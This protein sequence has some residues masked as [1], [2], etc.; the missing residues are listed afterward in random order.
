MKLFQTIVLALLL[1]LVTEPS[2]GS[3]AQAQT[4]K[5]AATAS[6]PSPSTKTAATTP[7]DVPPGKRVPGSRTKK[8]PAADWVPFAALGLMVF[9]FVALFG[10]KA[11]KSRD[12]KPSNESVDNPPSS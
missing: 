11:L 9:F 7:P 6:Q 1:V 3:E 5:S 10:F 12:A 8:G 4:V 2:M